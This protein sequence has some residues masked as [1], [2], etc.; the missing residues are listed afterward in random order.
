MDTERLTLATGQSLAREPAF[1]AEGVA[2]D[3]STH[4]SE[5]RRPVGA[6]KA[7]C[8]ATVEFCAYPAGAARS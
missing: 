2:A 4:S 8:V 6:S 7:L 1:V 5:R 3:F